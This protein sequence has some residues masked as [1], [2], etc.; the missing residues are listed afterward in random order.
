MS[1]RSR[2]ARKGKQRAA[3]S[4]AGRS[5]QV[6]APVEPT[7][8]PDEPGL[9]EYTYVITDLRRVTILATAMFALL[10]AL[11]FFIR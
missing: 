6:S 7:A 3:A 10:V 4:A 2:R 9:H 5:S 1:K 11:S 8:K